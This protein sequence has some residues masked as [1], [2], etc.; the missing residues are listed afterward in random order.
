MSYLNLISGKFT[1]LE[2]TTS[3]DIAVEPEN[4]VV[5]EE[6]TSSP[7]NSSEVSE[8]IDVESEQL[9]QQ[10]ILDVIDDLQNTSQECYSLLDTIKTYKDSG[11]SQEAFQ[12]ANGH[13]NAIKYRLGIEHTQPSLE[14]TGDI[15][16]DVISLEEESKGIIATIWAKIKQFFKWLKDKVVGF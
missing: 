7:E 5:I 3:D 10:N 9:Q 4:A 15:Y 8:D 14:S 6:V 13:L 12:F 2:D 11:I 16:S 1:G